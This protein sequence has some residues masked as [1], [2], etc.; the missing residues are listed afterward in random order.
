VKVGLRSGL[1]VPMLVALGACAGQVPSAAAPV[2]ASPAALT[3]AVS[4]VAA[5][6]SASASSCTVSVQ[7]DVVAQGAWSI[8]VGTG[9][10]P[11][12]PVRW[13]HAAE[14]GTLE[15]AWDSDGYEAMRPDARGG[16]AFGLGGAGADAVGHTF[17]ATISS[18]SCT[19]HATWRIVAASEPT[20]PLPTTA[21]A[22]CAIARASVDRVDDVTGHQVHLIY[23]VP[24][25]GLDLEL[26]RRGQI[27]TS[28]DRV[29]Q[30]LRERL[31]GSAFRLDTCDGKLDITF[32]RLSRPAAEY[33]AMRSAFV[34]GL[35]LELDR[36]G[37][38]W[39][40]KLFV[41]VWSG[42]AQWARLDV[43]CGGDAGYHGV[44]VVYRFGIGGETCPPI[45]SELPIGEP[46][47]GLA[48]EIIH[49]LGLPAACGA[50]VDEGGHVADDP[51]D[52]MYGRGH[53]T[54]DVI[55]AAH[56]D[57]YRHGIAGCPDL[58]RSAFLDPLPAH[59]ELPQGWPGD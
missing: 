55:D 35:E 14:D 39:G 31:D 48:H 40:Q 44:A 1:F 33:A 43:G 45:A 25:D 12:E 7:P 13:K 4:N 15:T 42:L 10:A 16:F 41:V 9:F 24:S 56:D 54:A 19:A 26:D 20:G 59:P 32:L 51:A 5:A 49:L 30:Y 3:P 46:D 34:Q 50:N 6:P 11:G 57:Y 37:F 17:T 28:L 47:T 22:S 8:I 36:H 2:T 38:S 27:A 52:L 53:T 21:P 58:A 18:A 29:Q 23:A